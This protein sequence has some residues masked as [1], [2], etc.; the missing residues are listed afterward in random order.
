REVL[1]RSP[2]EVV[3]LLV[4]GHTCPECEPDQVAE[5]VLELPE[6]GVGGRLELVGR[7]GGRVRTGARVRHAVIPVRRG[8]K[9]PDAGN[10]E[11]LRGVWIWMGGV[12]ELLRGQERRSQP[13]LV[14]VAVDPQ[15][16]NPGGPV[17]LLV[18]AVQA[19]FERLLVDLA[20]VE[21]LKQRDRGGIGG[22]LIVLVQR[23]VVADDG[24]CGAA[25]FARVLCGQ[26]AAPELGK[27]TDAV[28]YDERAAGRQARG[29][30]ARAGAV[31]VVVRAG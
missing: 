8:A 1:V 18:A 13:P 4:R 5:A 22:F 17:Q 24:E 2:R 14:V 25:E 10:A 15:A 12:V 11:V 7:A 27:A 26:T 31:R 29:I 23:A 21:K 30:A 19:G 16:V 9:R 3:V 28:A 6:A 20:A